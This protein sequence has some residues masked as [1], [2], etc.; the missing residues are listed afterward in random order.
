MVGNGG[1]E[2]AGVVVALGEGVRSLQLGQRVGVSAISGCGEC[3]Y[4]QRGQYTW[5]NQRSF[6]GNMHAEQFVVAARACH[7][8]PDDVEWGVGVLITGDGLG[9]PYHTSTKLP[10]HGIET[11]AVFGLGPI[12]LGGTLL[13]AYRG[14]RVIGIDLAPQRLALAK[15]IGASDTIDAG[16]TDDV[17]AAVRALTAG[18]GA[19]VCIEAAGRPETAKQCFGAVRTGGI[20]VF[21]GEQPSVTLSPSEDFIRR[22]VTA[23][24][25]WFYHFSEFP[26]MLALARSGLPV[27][28]LITHRYPLEE[29]DTAYREM[30]AGHTGKVVLEYAV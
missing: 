1:H 21:N 29:A 13:H 19:D 14:R 26:A 15:T 2:A 22:D 27:G 11:V 12:G 10:E 24:G 30:S 17:V 5:C 8:L 4:C 16:E 9:V 6:Y 20:V 23:F 3:E 25:A 18:K 7:V 28:W